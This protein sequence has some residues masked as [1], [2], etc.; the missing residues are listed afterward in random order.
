MS[1]EIS[2]AT[3]SHQ[4]DV[5]VKVRVDVGGRHVSPR[6]STEYRQ[7]RHHRLSLDQQM[8]EGGTRVQQAKMWQTT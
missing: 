3:A 4:P 2:D 1:Y 6:H 8:E 5:E 7:Q